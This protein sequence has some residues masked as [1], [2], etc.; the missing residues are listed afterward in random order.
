MMATLLETPLPVQDSPRNAIAPHR[1]HWLYQGGEWRET[2]SYNFDN[3]KENVLEQE[4]WHNDFVTIYRCKQTTL[5]LT[6]IVVVQFGDDTYY[7]YIQEFPDLVR[8]MNELMVF[9][10]IGKKKGK[11]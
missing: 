6:Y 5:S 9:P 4:K 11:K 2:S 1:I 7:I 3:L 10:Q 8:L